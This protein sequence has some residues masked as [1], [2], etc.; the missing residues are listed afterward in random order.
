M[1]DLIHEDLNR[2][3]DKPFTELS[4]VPNRSDVEVAKEYWENHTARN[5]SIIVDLMHGQL[6]STITCLTCGRLATAFDPYL[7]IQLPIDA[8]EE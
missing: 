2:V 3:I 1:L 8:L 6:K 7:S 5:R 4:D